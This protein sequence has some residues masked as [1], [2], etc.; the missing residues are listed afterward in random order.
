LEDQVFWYK[1]EA[2]DDFKIGADE[3]CKYHN[4][5]FEEEIPEDDNE[6]ILSMNKKK[7]RAK[8]IVKRLT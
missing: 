2:H 8:I 4:Y 5:N 6:E 1:A 7:N 3:Y